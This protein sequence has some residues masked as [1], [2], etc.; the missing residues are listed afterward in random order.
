MR[1]LV[2]A[3]VGKEYSEPT[4][5][6]QILGSIENPYSSSSYEVVDAFSALQNRTENEIHKNFF[7]ILLC[8]KLFEMKTRMVFSVKNSCFVFWS[9]FLCKGY[10]VVFLPFLSKVLVQICR[11]M[12]GF[13]RRTFVSRNDVKDWMDSPSHFLLFIFPLFIV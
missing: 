13:F 10:C 11:K 7:K 2:G 5:Y 3:N 6:E 9:T 1:G 4:F 12:W 8:L